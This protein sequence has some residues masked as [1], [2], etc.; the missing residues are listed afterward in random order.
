MM[1]GHKVS[2]PYMRV[3]FNGK[4]H[5]VQ[6]RPGEEGMKDFEHQIRNMLQLPEDQDFDVSAESKTLA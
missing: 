3:S 2:T 6:V 5:K 4:T 1:N